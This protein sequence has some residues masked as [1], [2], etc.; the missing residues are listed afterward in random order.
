[1]G[2]RRSNFT[3]LL[4]R[5]VKAAMAAV[6]IPLAVGLVLGMLNQLES[7][8]LAGSTARRWIEWGVGAY[9]GLHVLLY[10]PVAVFRASHRL[11]ASL[12]VWL[13]G[14]QVAS[15][16]SAGGADRKGSKGAKGEA[17]A[18]GS[19]LVAFSP[20]VIPLYTI[21]VCGLSWLLRRSVDRAWLDALTCWLIGATIAFHWLMTADELQQQR[22]RWHVET[23][24]LAIGLVFVVTL[25]LGGAC[26]PGAIPE[27]S[28]TQA[29]GDGLSRAQAMYATLIQR[30]FL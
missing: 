13:F 8:T 7:V 23:Y 21:L 19:P 30:L 28:F 1:M 20:Y 5:L 3:A 11:F 22:G 29:L 10:R 6:V 25:L 24:L 9:V 2:T 26:L 18:M 4:A 16:E 27:F 15:V 14:G 17:G 12:A